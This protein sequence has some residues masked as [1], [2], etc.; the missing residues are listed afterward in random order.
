MS[1]LKA[2]SG[3]LQASPLGTL[4]D[5]AIDSIFPE[6]LTEAE[7]AQLR[8]MVSRAEHDM[9]RDIERL[10]MEK[11]A[12]FNRRI[13]EMEGTAK[14][15][16]ALPV[17]G[18]VVLFLRG[19]QRPAWGFATLWLDAQWFGGFFTDLSERQEA[20]LLAINLLVLVFL[21]GERAVQNVMPFIVQAFGRG[22]Q[23]RGSSK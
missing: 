17:I 18:R 12:E 22:G 8:L 3:L 23:D 5:R 14:D 13:A 1:F 19:L 10:A 7:K 21:F 15:L 2:V 6:K 16:K 4:A 9:Q 11:D 20:A